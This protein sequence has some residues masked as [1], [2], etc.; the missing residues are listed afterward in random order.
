MADDKK[1]GYCNQ[2]GKKV[3]VFRKGTNHIL[4]LIMT[5]LTAGLWLFIWIGSCIKF[6]GWRCNE[7]GSGKVRQ[8]R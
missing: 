8:V 5:L 6:G 7:C 3:V 4:H 1:G 2:C